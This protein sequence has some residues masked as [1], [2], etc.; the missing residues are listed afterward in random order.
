MICANT[1]L[2][3]LSVDPDKKKLYLTRKKT[4]V[5]STLR[6]FLSYD[7]ALPGRVSHGYVVCVK[8]FGC[9]VRFYNNVKGLVPLRELSS[10]TIMSPE[11]V[12]YV[13]QV[14]PRWQPVNMVELNE[15][16]VLTHLRR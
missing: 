3:V 8:D 2:Q 15:P 16:A 7:D 4:L 1:C 13:G 10:E 6:L 11:T 12:F 5:D 14:G 9:I